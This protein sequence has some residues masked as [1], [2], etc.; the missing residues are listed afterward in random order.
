M[1]R[2]NRTLAVTVTDTASRFADL[3]VLHVGFEAYGQDEQ[4][5]YAAGSRRSNAIM[6]ALTSGGVPKNTIESESQ[7]LAPLSE[8]ELRN[9]PAALKGMRF[10]LT[11]SWTLRTRP[12]AAA[13]LLDL[14]VKAGANQSGNID[15]QMKDASLLESQA[16][17]KALAHARAI[18]AGMAEGLHTRLG[19][20]LYASNQSQ[21]SRGGAPGGAIDLF[22][23]EGVGTGTAGHQQSQGRAIGDGST[24]SLG[25]KKRH[26]DLPNSLH[27]EN[28]QFFINAEDRNVCFQRLCRNHPVEWVF[29]FA[30]QAAGAQRD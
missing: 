24:W 9:Q 19:P 17:A 14:A 11:Q 10:R 30:P 15:W 28:V 27:S 25:W 7:A 8:Y 1:S 23:S 22:K 26:G 12:D 21:E 13:K 29:V 3:A 5:A 2:D 6:D 4:S 18:A 16:A 20:L